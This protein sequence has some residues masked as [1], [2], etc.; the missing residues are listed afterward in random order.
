MFPFKSSAKYKPR[1]YVL[2]NLYGVF[3]IG[4]KTS[5][6]TGSKSESSDPSRT[7]VRV[8]PGNESYDFRFSHENVLQGL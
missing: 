4:Y 6:V 7:I 2:E 3:E 1:F 8:P 5:A